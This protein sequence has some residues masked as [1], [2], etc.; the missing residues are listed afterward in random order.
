MDM[1]WG[2]IEHCSYVPHSAVLKSNPHT[3]KKHNLLLQKKKRIITKDT[4][5]L[6]DERP[7]VI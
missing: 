6:Q 5:I 7:I 3:N 1:V 2:T 4:H